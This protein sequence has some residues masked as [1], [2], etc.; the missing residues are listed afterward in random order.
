MPTL[1]KI[2]NAPINP[3]LLA[4]ELAPLG[5]SVSLW[6]GF[7]FDGDNYIPSKIHGF[8]SGELH[9]AAETDPGAALDAAL[10]NHDH[11]Q[12][13]AE[14]RRLAARAADRAQ[15]EAAVG[16]APP[17]TPDDLKAMARLLLEET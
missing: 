5:V 13:S 9:L 7:D 16:K 12:Q 4:E 17:M 3:T 6:A 2:R 15:V 1:V 8:A 10:A 11:T 14:Q